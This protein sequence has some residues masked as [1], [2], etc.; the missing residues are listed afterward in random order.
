MILY[1]LVIAVHVVAS[2]VLIC[3]ILLQAGR[4]GGLNEQFGGG[5]T[6]TIFGTKTS[7]FLMR[8]T[9]V[10]AVLY[11]FTC[12]AL[13]VMTAHMGRSLVSK[14]PVTLPAGRNAPI[15]PMAEDMVDY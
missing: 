12:L 15:S 7:V 13:G 9:G 5:A 11:I 10:C 2:L 3:V 6:Q 1:W 4:G 8:A 14:G